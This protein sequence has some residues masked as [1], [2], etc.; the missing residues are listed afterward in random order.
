[1]QNNPLKFIIKYGC[2]ALMFYALFFAFKA[3][4]SIIA[5]KAPASAP[6]SAWDQARKTHIIIA[7][8][9]LMFAAA[10]YK[11]AQIYSKLY[12]NEQILFITNLPSTP[13]YQNTKQIELKKLG[14]TIT[15]EDTEILSS[16]YLI[17]K[18]LTYTNQIR[19]FTIISHNGVE[20]GPWLEDSNYRFDWDNEALMSQ[21]TPAFTSDA[22][23]RVQGCNSG[24]YVGP[25][26]SEYWGIPVIVSFT[27]TSFYYLSE[28]GSYELYSSV[29]GKLTTNAIKPAKKD[30]WAFTEEM[31]CPAGL[32]V[33]LIPEPAPY[34]YNYHQDSNAA[35][36]PMAKP[37]CADSIP[38]ER[39]QKTLAEV[40]INGTGAIS[41]EEM[42]KDKNLFK[43]MVYQSICAS[44]YLAKQQIACIDQL[45][46]AY[47]Q[48]VEYFPYKI[49]TMLKCSGIRD[50]DF[51]DVNSNVRTNASG[52]ENSIFEY[53]NDA[54]VGYNYLLG[55][56]N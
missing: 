28:K 54:L 32:C 17:P 34:H 10:A 42:L 4:S 55:V 8:K 51:T 1:M 29:D 47:D 56:Q 37:V 12:P 30:K 38:T 26:L 35:W 21:L 24:W 23:A 39:C 16:D 50:C 3:E 43:T 25:W 27:S 18:V 36:L 5:T 15:E 53:I 9:G 33:T 20:F 48:Q 49:G 19:S 45:A 44:Y 7:G 6:D 13:A 40:I 2:Y 31:P 22:W 46:A 14:F 41:K 52:T 11:Q